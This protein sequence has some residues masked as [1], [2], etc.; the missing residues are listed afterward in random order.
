M[1]LSMHVGLKHT[2]I[3]CEINP[4]F[5]ALPNITDLDVALERS[6]DLTA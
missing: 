2:S 3:I 1:Q 5:N 4:E 6:L